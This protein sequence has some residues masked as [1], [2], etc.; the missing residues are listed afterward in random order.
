L[1][2]TAAGK[3]NDAKF[4]GGDLVIATDGEGL[5]I[6]KAAVGKPVSK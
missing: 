6:R 3:I 1:L 4:V 5:I 2:T